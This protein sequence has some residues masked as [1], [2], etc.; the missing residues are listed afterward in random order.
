MRVVLIDLLIENYLINAPQ[1]RIYVISAADG[2]T[3]NVP[4]V[5]VVPASTSVVTVTEYVGGQWVPLD[6]PPGITTRIQIAH[7]SERTIAV[8]QESA[9][10]PQIP[11]N[12]PEP[13]GFSPHEFFT[14][15]ISFMISQPRVTGGSSGLALY[16][17]WQALEK[18]LEPAQDQDVVDVAC[19]SAEIE[20]GSLTDA[21]VASCS[22]PFPEPTPSPTPGQTP[23]PTPTPSPQT[24]ILALGVIAV[25]PELES[26]SQPAADE[27]IQCSYTLHVS[28]DY[29]VSALPAQIE[30]RIRDQIPAFSPLEPDIRDLSALSGLVNVSPRAVA[31]FD[32]PDTPRF[33][34]PT[35]VECFLQVPVGDGTFRNLDSAVVEVSLPGPEL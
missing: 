26:C 4:L 24:G 2:V 9:G 29:E 35:L 13:A 5:L 25:G 30:C 18:I 27:P 15:C 31:Q 22:S 7:F 34:L 6:V 23:A 11:L 3:L 19:L 20:G 17:C 10:T 21:A 33:S 14:G 28:T 16:V 32:P 12:S 8:S 1:T